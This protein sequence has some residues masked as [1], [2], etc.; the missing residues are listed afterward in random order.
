MNK[1]TDFILTPITTILE[2]AVAATS[3]L[4]DGIETYAL[5]DY[6]M[7]SVFLKMTGFQEQKMKCIAWEI[8]THNF[9]Y[10]RRLLNNEDKL[11]EYSSY[12]AKQKIYRTLLSE[13][14]ELD[15]GNTK[16]REIVSDVV[17]F[18]K[19]TFKKSTLS[20]YSSK[21][22]IF[23]SQKA[24][25]EIIKTTQ[26][27]NNNNNLLENK[28]QEIYTSLYNH[29]NRVAHNTFSYQNNLPTLDTLH[30]EKEVDRNYFVWF[31]VLIL[32]DSIFIEL[33]KEY[34]IRLQSSI[35]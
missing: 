2:E 10:R 31:A 18:I 35:Y 22:F 26:F 14:S 28:L 15:F 3:G 17:D 9:S 1:H 25:S 12:E 16:K 33:Y 21:K 20:T 32:I 6:V 29:R 27:L 7:Q 30:S 4:G 8:A 11:G 5:C 34:L 19:E 24:R 23:F 13:V